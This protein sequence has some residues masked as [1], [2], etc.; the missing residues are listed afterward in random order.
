MQ[1]VYSFLVA[2]A[3]F[4]SGFAQSKIIDKNEFD[5]AVTAAAEGLPQYW[6]GK[7]FRMIVTTQ[8]H[9]SK[10]PDLDYSSKAVSELT[11]N[12][13][14]RNIT[15]TSMGAN[16]NSGESIKIGNDRYARK[17]GGPWE[18]LA[19][20]A[21]PL[22]PPTPRDPTT[23]VLNSEFEYNFL[24]TES[25]KGETARTYLRTE[26]RTEIDKV[27]GEQRQNETTIKY[28]VAA[29]GHIMKSDFLGTTKFTDWTSTT[30]VVMEYE[31]D[32]SITI[33]AP[34]VGA[35]AGAAKAN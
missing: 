28:W 35:G 14:N 31:L 15:E 34:I 2:A 1:I 9:S 6:I 29:D 32:P 22:A 11:G 27:T 16:R 5:T 10:R 12:G 4:A 24:G 30:K 20:A 3:C 33:T 8:T 18:K 25:F 19:T 21:T 7:P 13:S 17:N 26:R 23:N